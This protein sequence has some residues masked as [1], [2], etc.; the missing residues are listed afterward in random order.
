MHQKQSS[1]NVKLF[2]HLFH[3]NKKLVLLQLSVQ[4][5]LL[6]VEFTILKKKY[7]TL[8]NKLTTLTLIN[9]ATCDNEKYKV[10]IT[11]QV[12]A[13]FIVIVIF[14]MQNI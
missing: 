10:I 13:S 9:L 3:F 1:R 12:I 8:H 6:R 7:Q 4:S 2:K 5:F 14:Y 11:I